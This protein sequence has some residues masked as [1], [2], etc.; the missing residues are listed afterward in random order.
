MKISKEELPQLCVFVCGGGGRRVAMG[1]D[2]YIAG[3][4]FACHF[5]HIV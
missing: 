2:I 5:S 3:R 4:C 1:A